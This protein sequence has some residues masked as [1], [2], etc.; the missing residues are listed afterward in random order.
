M[1]QV[2]NKYHV[3]IVSYTIRRIISQAFIQ[4]ERNENKKSCDFFV[5]T[6]RSPQNFGG[7]CQE[8][9]REWVTLIFYIITY[10]VIIF[11]TETSGEN[12]NTVLKVFV[13]HSVLV[14]E[15]SRS[16]NGFI[17]RV[18]CIARTIESIPTNFMYTNVST[19]R[20]RDGWL[21]NV[22]RGDGIFDK[23]TNAFS[24]AR[25][26]YYIHMLTHLLRGGDDDSVFI[27]LINYGF[28]NSYYYSLS[29]V[30]TSINH[31]LMLYVCAYTNAIPRQQTVLD[32]D[33]NSANSVCCDQGRIG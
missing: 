32:V 15:F 9:E 29:T 30:N 4:F 23:I 13:K 22:K 26:T 10:F 19:V 24:R 28:F 14:Y 6:V 18:I 31:A 25:I 33:E 11:R 7:S 27:P 16:N 20:A 12:K 8:N 1:T 2:N 21:Q 17:A 3:K 5:I